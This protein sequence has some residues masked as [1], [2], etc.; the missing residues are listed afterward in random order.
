MFL[1]VSQAAHGEDTCNVCESA[2]E[3]GCHMGGTRLAFKPISGKGMNDQRS[4]GQAKWTGKEKQKA[5]L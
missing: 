5:E 1:V 3:R 2:L 4:C